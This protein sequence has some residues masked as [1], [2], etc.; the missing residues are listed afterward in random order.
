MTHGE[1]FA[2]IGGFGLAAHWAGIDTLWANEIDPFA[3]KVLRKN[4]P[5]T[6]IYEKDIRE[7][8]KETTPSVDIIS[9]GFPCQPFSQAGR[10]KGTDDNRYLWPEMLRVIR[11]LQPTYVIGE[12]VAGLLSMENGE[13]LKTIL[14]DL[15]N[16]GY[17]NEVFLIPACAKGAWHRRDRLWII[18][19]VSD[20]DNARERT[21]RSRDNKNREKKDKGWKEQPQFE[22]GRYSQDATNTDNTGL[23][24]RDKQ[25]GGS[26][27]SDGEG[28]DSV[29]RCGT[30]RDVTNPSTAGL[31]G[32]V[33]A[34][35]QGS[36]DGLTNSSEDATNTDT[37]PIQGMEQEPQQGRHQRQIGLHSGKT[38]QCSRSTESSMGG[39]ADGVS[40]RVDRYWDNEPEGVPRVA[41]GVKNR[42]GRLKGLGNAIVPAMA[43]EIFKTIQ[44]Y[45]I[46]RLSSR[47]Y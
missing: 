5:N 43:Y 31:Q 27:A 18:S 45:E 2:G 3:A 30:S 11:E 35:S 25:R 28:L 17:N 38:E 16:E 21:S 36:G 14:S 29:S 19:H 10:R 20:T 46:Q 22:S 9:G 39:V 44:Q 34:Q 1:L 32:V 33:G 6:T 37:N 42:V 23:S 13:T 40:S 7:I 12:N 4:F 47:D 24:D 15:E 26:Q 8:T 41:K